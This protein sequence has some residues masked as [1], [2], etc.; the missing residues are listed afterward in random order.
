V[1]E[2]IY[3]SRIF[4]LGTSWRSV[5]GFEPRPLYFRERNPRYPLDRR[6]DRRRAGLKSVKKRIYDP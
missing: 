5:V 4:Y 1:E 6:L 2:W 3:R